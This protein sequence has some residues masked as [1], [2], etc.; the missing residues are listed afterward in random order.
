MSQ[1]ALH[2]LADIIDSSVE[3]NDTNVKSIF[4]ESLNSVVHIGTES[5]GDMLVD[6]IK[7]LVRLISS[8][9]YLLGRAI[10]KLY[11]FISFKLTDISEHVSKLK[12]RIRE[13]NYIENVFNNI[14]VSQGIKYSVFI[15]TIYAINN[16]IKNLKQVF[17]IFDLKNQISKIADLEYN[18]TGIYLPP[19]KFIITESSYSLLKNDLELSGI[20]I[21]PIKSEI[22]N[23]DTV[24]TNCDIEY[25][26]VL[27]RSVEQNVSLKDLGYT[28]ENIIKSYNNSFNNF[29]SLNKDAIS[30][31]STLESVKKNLEKL[32]SRASYLNAENIS[33]PNHKVNR[34]RLLV[35][36]LV[37]SINLFSKISTASAEYIGW[38]TQL[39]S[40]AANSK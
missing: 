26:S 22:S 11:N 9:I 16:S 20:K 23:R 32:Q 29:Y 35:A 36:N 14:K 17:D 21:N 1:S 40:I 8:I 6:L 28:P 12:K 13:Q 31:L 30:Y 7:Q 3:I 34:V 25:N 5:I 15:D 27:L 10:K 4:K 19:T 37:V 18:D 33:D 39:T 24:Y 2:Y 38:F